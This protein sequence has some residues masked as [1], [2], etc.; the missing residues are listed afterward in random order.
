MA[1]I[2]DGDK[3]LCYFN[4][5][6]VVKPAIS[7]FCCLESSSF[8]WIISPHRPCC[9]GLFLEC[10]HLQH[11]KLEKESCLII[12]SN[13]FFAAERCIHCIDLSLVFWG[14]PCPCKL[15][16]GGC[17]MWPCC[18]RYHRNCPG[19]PRLQ[20]S[21]T[22]ALSETPLFSSSKHTFQYFFFQTYR[23]MNSLHI[24]Y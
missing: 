20:H 18:C 1:G 10:R 16:V 12:A 23:N 19:K 21:H 5:F 24:I 7:T 2:Q 17:A 11:L 6:S 14:L 4:T 8:T 22:M 15:L 9:V 3:K 13:F